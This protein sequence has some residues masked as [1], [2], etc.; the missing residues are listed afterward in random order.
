VTE[1]FA[2]VRPFGEWPSLEVVST[3]TRQSLYI[4]DGSIHDRHIADVDPSKI[5]MRGIKVYNAAAANSI[6]NA[7]DTTV[8]FDTVSFVNDFDSPTGTF[9]TVT[10]PRDGIYLVIGTIEWAAGDKARSVWLYVN[11]AKKDGDSRSSDA[12]SMATRQT[13]TS[14]RK[15]TAGDTV[16]LR[17]RQNDSGLGAISISTGE[18]NCAL[19]VLY[20]GV[21]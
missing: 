8:N 20:L 13:I 3:D 9:T 4:P 11:S 17:V 12:D 10:I 1:D 15:L 2:P 21:I 5:A 6:A 14:A 7:T 16:A 19:T 18:D